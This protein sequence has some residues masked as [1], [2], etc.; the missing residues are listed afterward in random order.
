[1]QDEPRMR[2]ERILATVD[3][4]P[5]GRVS[6]YGRIAAEAGLGRGA[7]EVGRAL[8]DLPSGRKIAWHRVVNAAGKISLGDP[9]SAQ[10]QRLLLEAEGVEFSASGRIDLKRFGWPLA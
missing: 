7:R 2:Y 1:M 3:S 5:P 8:R 6:T 10:N 4:I 9:D